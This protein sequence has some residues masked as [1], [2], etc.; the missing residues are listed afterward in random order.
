MK[1]YKR[2]VIRENIEA[3]HKELSDYEINI[4]N[5]EYIHARTK[6][7]SFKAQIAS[8]IEDNKREMAKTQLILEALEAQLA[9]LE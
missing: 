1:E 4:F 6:D 2:N 5:Y 3:R 9:S 7:E 8:G